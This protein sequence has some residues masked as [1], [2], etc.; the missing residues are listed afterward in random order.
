M[1]IFLRPITFDQF[2]LLNRIIINE[3]HSLHPYT[4]CTPIRFVLCSRDFLHGPSD[5]PTHPSSV[6]EEE[7]DESKTQNSISEQKPSIQ[8]PANITVKHSH[9]FSCLLSNPCFVSLV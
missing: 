6:F 5:G 1:Y 9:L 3:S 8:T 4:K 2:I 7:N